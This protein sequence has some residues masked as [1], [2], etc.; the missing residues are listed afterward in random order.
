MGEVAM[1]SPI[2]AN[3]SKTF[4]DEKITVLTEDRLSQLFE[5]IPQ[6]RVEGINL[7]TDNGLIRMFGIYQKLKKQNFD[8]VIDLQDNIRSK[9]LIRLFLMKHLPCYVVKDGKKEKKKLVSGENRIQMKT[10][11]ERYWEVFQRAGLPFSFPD[12][13][14]RRTMPVP[15]SI[16]V[17]TGEK[18][19]R[20]YGIAPFAKYK[21]KTYPPDKAKKL[22]G[23]LTENNNDRVFIFCGAEEKR[24]AEKLTAGFPNAVTVFGKVSLKGEIELMSNLDVLVSTDSAAMHLAS[25][26]GTRVVSVWGATHRYAGFLG[27]GQDEEDAVELEMECR[28]CSVYGNRRC[29]NGDYPCIKDIEPEMIYD[30]IMKK[31]AI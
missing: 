25:L 17:I 13:P 21:G 4:P 28:P 10:T 9:I 24:A 3:M 8:R 12:K 29:H 5:D 26:A 23:M 7:R 15:Y 16:S 18:R 11:M 2:V 31:T 1:T 30:R 14:E 22:I 27:W 6:V 20:W 19:G